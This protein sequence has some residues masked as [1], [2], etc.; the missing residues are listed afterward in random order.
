MACCPPRLSRDAGYATPLAMVFAL[1]L[2]MIVAAVL[3]RSLVEVRR[4]RIELERLKVDYA[5][6]GAQLIAAT[7]IVRSGED[8]PF[9]WSF[10]SDA[11][12]VEALA[13]PE[14]PK[15]DFLAA[16]TLD[17]AR[18]RS[19]GANDPAFAKAALAQAAA[20]RTRQDIRAFDPSARWRD[21]AAS[22]ISPFGE[23]ETFVYAMPGEPRVT[24]KPP[25][26]RVGETW[27]LRLTTSAGWRDERIVR[28]TG[29]ARRPFAT[30]RRKL[31]R[32]VKGEAGC[33]A[34]LQAGA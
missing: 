8:G 15:L 18:L 1:A 33:D 28:F 34:I 22:M 3:S 2:A 16:S 7:T 12:W 6:A 4:S 25:A 31:T 9:R 19:L 13:E 5:L 24:K 30:V 10:S 29:D 23:A 27:R 14:A 17:D 26:W 11:G 21:C 32:G 20:D